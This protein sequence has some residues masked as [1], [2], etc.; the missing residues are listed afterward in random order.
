[1]V[2]FN[3]VASGSF[4]S[5]VLFDAAR[6]SDISLDVGS[7]ESVCSTNS[8]GCCRS[9]LTSDSEIA[10]VSAQVIGCI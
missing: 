8:R 7:V 1:M 10:I 3:S 9:S 6:S 2:S 4:E 5:I